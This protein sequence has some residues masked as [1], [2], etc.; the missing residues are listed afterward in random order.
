M[1]NKHLAQHVRKIMV[2]CSCNMNMKMYDILIFFYML[3][4]SDMRG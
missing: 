2:R 4:I 3:Q 1:N